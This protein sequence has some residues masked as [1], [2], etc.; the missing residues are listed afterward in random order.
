VR[1]GQAGG[2]LKGDVD[3][4]LAAAAIVGAIAA[5]TSPARAVRGRDGRVLPALVLA[6]LEVPDYA[7]T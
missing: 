3:P 5:V 2:E 4:E 7:T 6:G 1:R